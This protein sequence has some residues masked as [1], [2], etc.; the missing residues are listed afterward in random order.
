MN[1]E[2]IKIYL[3][4]YLSPDSE[5]ALFEGLRD[6][7]GN[8]DSRL[9]TNYLTDNEVIYQGDGLKDMLVIN[10]PE[11][12]IGKGKC[13]IISNTCDIDPDNP[14]FFPSQV[15]YAPIFNL[16]KYCERLA[17]ILGKTSAQI[18][19]HTEAIRKQ[20]IT[21]I[22][23]LPEL[24]G[25]L[26]ESI[27]FLDRLLNFPSNKIERKA[28][29]KIRLFSLSDYGSYLF[30]FKLSLHFTRIQEKVERR[31]LSN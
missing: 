9:Y 12:T 1:F 21:Q 6:F 22:F 3:P 18:Q 31:G 16:R 5:R 10:L 23:Y 8:I 24:S 15:V 30:L 14:R 7:P 20:H 28:I 2:D 26:E 13:M 17:D 25:V 29:P 27:V 11:T 4:K 19:S